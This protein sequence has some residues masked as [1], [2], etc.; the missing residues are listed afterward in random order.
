MGQGQAQ[1]ELPFLKL[2]SPAFPRPAF[3]GLLLAVL[4]LMT[5]S[6]VALGIATYSR[7]RRELEA[8][9]AQRLVN[10]AKLLALG[11][12][13]SLVT[14]FREGDEQIPAYQLVAS[15]FVTLARAAGGD[16]AYVVGD[17]LDTPVGS[18]PAA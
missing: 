10:V 14:Q 7:L 11:T 17:R 13:V 4:L 6:E 9:L 16:R 12:D 3:G 2:R 18:W 5:V 1:Q 8:D 15:R